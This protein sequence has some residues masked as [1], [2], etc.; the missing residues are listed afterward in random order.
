MSTR[1]AAWIAV[2]LGLLNVV[3]AL[4]ALLFAGLNGYSL[5]LFIEQLTLPSAILTV[6]FSV[7]G[8]IV[9]SRI[10]N[11]P[12][13]WIFLAVG[14]SQ[15]L[16]QFAGTYAEYVLVTQG[17]S[18]LPGAPLMSWLGGWAW[19]PGYGLLL[20]FVP[21]L[22]PDGRL[23]SRRWRPVAWLSVVPFAI[24][25]PLAIWMWPY[26][27]RRSIEYPNRPPCPTASSASSLICNTRSCWHAGWLA[28][29]H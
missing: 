25:V 27:G 28:L 15:G 4:L 24:L 2:P 26:R 23:P 10:P 8:V 3:L 29:P 22:F 1:T 13:G 6:S 21:L 11:K 7:V 5:T 9:A 16:V 17:G 12:L 14:F 20:T 19:F 18:S